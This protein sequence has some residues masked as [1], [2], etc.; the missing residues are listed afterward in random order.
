MTDVFGA[1]PI[2]PL[3]IGVGVLAIVG[4]IVQAVRT[5][6]GRQKYGQ[7]VE[8]VGWFAAKMVL[9]T[10][11]VGAFAFALGSFKGI[12]VTLI[13]L[14]VL[15]LFYRSSPTAASSAATSTRSAATATRPS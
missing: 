9:V 14:G 12:P 3:T 13:V 11:G 2:D 10:L 8:P 4:F 7:E 15:V 5:R 6:L 1:Y